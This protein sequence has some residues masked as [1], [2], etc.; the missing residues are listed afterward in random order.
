[1]TELS[2]LFSCSEY[3]AIFNALNTDSLECLK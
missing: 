2:Q 3:Q 1:M